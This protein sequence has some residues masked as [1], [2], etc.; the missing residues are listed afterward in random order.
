MLGVDHRL[1]LTPGY[2]L[3]YDVIRALSDDVLVEPVNRFSRADR[4]RSFLSRCR[5]RLLRAAKARRRAR[6][7]V[8]GA[9]LRAR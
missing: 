8:E 6:D 3:L 5:R 1:R 9:A 2:P 4:M 7:L